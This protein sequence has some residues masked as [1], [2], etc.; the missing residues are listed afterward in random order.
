MTVYI[1]IYSAVL[2]FVLV[3][4]NFI[5]PP[6]NT[7]MPYILWVS[8]KTFPH[9]LVPST[10]YCKRSLTLVTHWHPHV[11]LGAKNNPTRIARS[12]VF[13]S[14][15]LPRCL[16]HIMTFQPMPSFFHV[17][18]A[19]PWFYPHTGSRTNILPNMLTQPAGRR[20]SAYHQHIEDGVI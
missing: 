17:T 15:R 20:P 11:S 7:K 19:P 2:S 5:T 12:T 4:R 9:L 16:T 18:G 1:Y 10:R 3:L 14:A 13:Y 6:I 8:M